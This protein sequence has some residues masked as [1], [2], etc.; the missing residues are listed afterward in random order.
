MAVIQFVIDDAKIDRLLAALAGLYPIPTIPDPEDPENL[1]PEF[2]ENQWGKECVRRWL[3]RQDARWRQK[4]ARDAVL[5]EGE[6][7][8]VQ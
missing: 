5:F 2:T 4:F 3:V 6:D 1:I 8:L 7:D